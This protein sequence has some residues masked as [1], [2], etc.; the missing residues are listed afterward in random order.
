M[1]VT[2]RVHSRRETDLLEIPPRLIDTTLIFAL[3]HCFVFGLR[4]CIS[5]RIDTP[6]PRLSFRNLP[7]GQPTVIPNKKSL[8]FCE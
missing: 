7:L 4:G 6:I 5:L 1:S 2:E 3:L 8:I